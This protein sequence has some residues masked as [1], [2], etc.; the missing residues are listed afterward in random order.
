MKSDF[1]FR[2]KKTSPP[3]GNVC[4][5][6]GDTCTLSPI[7]EDSTTISVVDCVKFSVLVNHCVRPSCSL[8]GST[9]P[10][11]KTTKNKETHY[12]IS[13]LFYET[14]FCFLMIFIRYFRGL[15]LF[16]ITN[17]VVLRSCIYMVVGPLKYTKAL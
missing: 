5:R 17:V 3:Y 7:V 11:K 4:I 14:W 1:F 15:A 16:S 12:I 13:V 9:Y 6:L 10:Q 8:V 2:K